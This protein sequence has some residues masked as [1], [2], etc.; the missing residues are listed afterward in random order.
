MRSLI[1]GN[2]EVGKSLVKVLEC[3]IRD[4]E[5][6]NGVFDIIH[7]CFPYWKKMWFQFWKRS[8]EQEVKRYQEIYNPQYTIVHSTVP[9][10]TCRRLGV[11]HSPVRGMHP[12]MEKSMKTFITYL[13]PAN[14]EISDYL[15]SKGMKIEMV[16][17]TEETEALK[18][19]DT[20]YYFWNII[21]EKEVHKFCEDTKLNFDVV[22]KHANETYNEGYKA[23]GKLYVRRPVLRHIEGKVSGHCLVPNAEILKEQHGFEIAKILL[24]MNNNL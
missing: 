14:V 17:K 20:T 21:F 13:A 19:F 8:F 16:N 22:Y 1:I 3:E 15:E 4:K 7:I 18:L 11:Y 5:D 10:G 12:E 9:I 6:I 24:S 2:G 23:M